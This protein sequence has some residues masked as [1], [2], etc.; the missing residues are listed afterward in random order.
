MSIWPWSKNND[1]EQLRE[2]LAGTRN[3]LTFVTASITHLR[4]R[5]H[6]LEQINTILRT[7]ND[8]MRHELASG[9]RRDPKTGRI[10]PKG[11]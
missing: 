3:R 7:Q 10:L 1:L 8:N 6:E 4:A 11:K 2:E 9:H 5:I